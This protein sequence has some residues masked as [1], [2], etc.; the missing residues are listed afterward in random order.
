MAQ[1][2]DDYGLDRVFLVAPSSTDQRVAKIVA[3]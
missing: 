3:A 2:S 1:G